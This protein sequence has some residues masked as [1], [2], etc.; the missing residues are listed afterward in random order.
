MKKTNF[1]YPTINQIIEKAKE[2]RNRTESTYTSDIIDA[3]YWIIDEIEKQ[4]L[5]NEKPDELWQ[6]SRDIYIA[7]QSKVNYNPVSFE[8]C[9]LDAKEIIK[10]KKQY[11]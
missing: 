1:N 2:L 9:I 6:L 7:K 8:E 4:Q 10:L 11:F 3:V 5:Q